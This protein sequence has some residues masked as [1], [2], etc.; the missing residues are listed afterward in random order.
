MPSRK[1]KNVTINTAALPTAA[2]TKNKKGGKGKGKGKH[3]TTAQRQAEIARYIGGDN[4]VPDFRQDK[5]TED[6]KEQ[7]S[8]KKVGVGVFAVVWWCVV[9]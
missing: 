9:G 8:L 6:A 3:L 7:A 2:G 4:V 1:I 5:T